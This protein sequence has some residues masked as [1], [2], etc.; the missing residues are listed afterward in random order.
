MRGEPKRLP[1]P[2]SFKIPRELAGHHSLDQPGV[3]QEAVE[4]ASLGAA[5]TLKE[6]PVAPLEYL[7]VFDKRRVERQ[8]GRLLD[9][10]RQIRRLQAVECRR[11]ILRL[12]VDRVEGVVGRE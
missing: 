1:L 9:N 8:S 6:Q 10:Q 11:H 3:D 7:L 2:R 5:G 12:K 4:T